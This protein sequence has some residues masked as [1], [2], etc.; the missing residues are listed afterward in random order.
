MRKYIPTTDN[1]GT[2]SGPESDDSMQKRC[3]RRSSLWVP[4]EAEKAS[5]G[6]LWECRALAGFLNLRYRICGD[7][8]D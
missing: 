8:S 4:P 7:Y 5:H 1:E 6:H 2:R 3:K